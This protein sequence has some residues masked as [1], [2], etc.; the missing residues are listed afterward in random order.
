MCKK[1][2]KSCFSK[3]E[4]ASRSMGYHR[5]GR[6]K[7]EEQKTEKQSGGLVNSK[8]LP[9]LAIGSFVQSGHALSGMSIDVCSSAKGGFQAERV[10][11]PEEV[12]SGVIFGRRLGLVFFVR[13]LRSLNGSHRLAD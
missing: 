7:N 2:K 1:K 6:A 12:H 8:P 4:E 11:L 5:E 9:H 13:R 10:V 3:R